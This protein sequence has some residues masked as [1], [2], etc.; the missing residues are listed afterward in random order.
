[1]AAE[2]ILS[3]RDLDF[4]LF[5]WLGVDGLCQRT[6]FA[7]HNRETLSAALDTY[8][9]IARERFEPHNKKSDQ[10]E[11]HFRDGTVAVIQEVRD[12][13]MAFSAAGLMAARQDYE[14][15]GM[16]LPFAVERAGM[17]M[18]MAANLA[19]SAFAFLTI[20]NAE[21]I[22][23]SD[24]QDRIESYVRPMMEGRFLGTMCLSEPQA[25]SSLADIRTKAL[26][27]ADGTYRLFGNK[28]WISAGDHDASDNIIHLVLAKVPGPDGQLRPGVQG[29]SLFLVPKW[30]VEEDGALGARNDVS[31][32]GL[33]HKMG[34][35]GLPNCL[36]NFGEGKHLPAGEAGAVGYLVGEEGQGLACMFRMMNEAR[37]AVGLSAAALGYT[38]YLHALDYA[39]TREQGR[40]PTGKRPTDPQVAIIRHADVRRMLLAQKAYA[41]GGMALAFY[42]ALL[43]DEQA[44]AT[45]PDA[46]TQ[47][48]QLLDLLT[49]V[50]KSWPSEWCLAANDLAIQVHGGYGYTREFNV[51]QFYRDNRLNPIHEGTF[52]IQANDLLGRKLRQH[53]GAA[54][55]LLGGKM[56]KT[57]DQA[58]SDPALAAFGASLS[59]AWS[60]VH[61]VATAVQSIPDDNIRLAN[62]A[63]FL[64]AFGHTIVA[65]IWLE[66]ALAASRLLQGA[67]DSASQDFYRGKLQACQY[68][69][70]W[71]LPKVFTWLALLDPVETTC[72]DMQDA[73]F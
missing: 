37:I 29:I 21:V 51:E 14:L 50:T 64:Q 71:E 45:D 9:T 44:T 17:S 40:L 2:R 65:W 73:W 8:Q 33:N 34:Y 13:L 56:R 31:P 11:P 43:I 12:A 60:K 41:E 30:L 70:R 5:D 54:L 47:A 6:R 18:L 69:H 4:M 23:A 22:L 32:A 26:P 38:G 66:Q 36:L 63:P 27:C 15:G 72:L 35:R 19:T 46:R 7:D 42:S 68:F 48:G 3:R 52:G 28:M 53:D 49:P 61:E 24:G 16:Q 39:R 58:N 25:G 55:T 67:E 59:A 1:M 10:N 57:I 20:A 62:A